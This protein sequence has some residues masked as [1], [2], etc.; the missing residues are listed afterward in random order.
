MTC[1]EP[2]SAGGAHGDCIIGKKLPGWGRSCQDGEEA[3]TMGKKL[4]GWEEVARM[5]TVLLCAHSL[6]QA[7]AARISTPVQCHIINKN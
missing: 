7:K 2:W 4:P 6:A 3:A 1:A 5:A